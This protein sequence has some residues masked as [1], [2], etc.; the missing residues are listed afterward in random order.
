MN[1]KELIQLHDQYVMSTYGRYPVA[2]ESG[3]GAVAVDMDGK[4]YVDFGSGIGANSLGYC[5]TGWVK[6]VTEQLGKI[7]HGSNY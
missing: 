7:Q 3:R 6:A 1:S 2:L 4:E 5:D